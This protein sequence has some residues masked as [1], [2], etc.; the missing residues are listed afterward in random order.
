MSVSVAAVTRRGEGAGI[1][2]V[3]GVQHQRDIQGPHAVGVGLLSPEHV[4]KVGG[5]AQVAIRGDR[6]LPMRSRSAAATIVAIWA[7]SRTDLRSLT[8]LP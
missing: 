2:F 1:E 6:G 3:V 7:V 4:Q 5:V 8:P